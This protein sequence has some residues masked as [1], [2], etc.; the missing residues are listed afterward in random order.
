MTY[1]I[2]P[3]H[4]VMLNPYVPWLAAATY[5]ITV[6][7]LKEVAKRWLPMLRPGER[8]LTGVVAVH[9]AFLCLLSV[10]MFFNIARY[11]AIHL[12]GE[13]RNYE[14]WQPWIWQHYCDPSRRVYEAAP[15][16]MFWCYVFYLSKYYEFLD[17]FFLALKGKQISFLQLFHHATVPIVCWSFHNARWGVHWVFA[18]ANAFVHVPMY[19]YFAVQSYD[20]ERAKGFWW[21]RY[22]TQIQIVQFIGDFS[23]IFPYTI[24]VFAYGGR[25]EDCNYNGFALYFN[26]IVVL[27]YLGL[28]VNFYL[29]TYRPPS[30]KQKKV[31]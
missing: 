18:L 5:L 24:Y 6:F 11:A 13:Y 27:A 19:F 20:P 30:T 1:T 7:A 2:L 25:V 14:S 29:R 16:L 17:T 9:N 8:R 4:D 28:F 22:L 3:W 10:V 26:A 23:L 12:I 31:E 21:K 15:Q